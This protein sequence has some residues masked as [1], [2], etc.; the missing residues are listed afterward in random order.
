MSFEIIQ[1]NLKLLDAEK[2]LFSHKTS[3]DISV[4][5]VYPNNY[6]AGMSNLGF[7]KVY[8]IINEIPEFFCDRAFLPDSKIMK[9]YGKSRRKLLSMAA[10]KPLQEFHILAFSISYEPDFL[11]IPKILDLSGIPIL[12]KDRKKSYPLLIAG[13]AAV[14][15][16]PEIVSSIFDLI[17]PGEAEEIL[18]KVLELYGRGGFNDKQAYIQE[19]AHISGVYAPSLFHISYDINGCISHVDNPHNLEFPVKMNRTRLLRSPA[20]SSIITNETEFSG[21]FLVEIS[22][23]CPFNCSFCHIGSSGAY[24]KVPMNEVIQAIDMGMKHTCK[25]GLLGAAVGSHPQLMDI[26]NYI[27]GKKGQVSFSSLRADVL[28]PK[29][30]QIFK[31]LGQNTITLAPESGSENLRKIL[32]KKMTNRQIMDVT[33]RAL[34]AGF[35]E[36]RLYFMTG[37]PGETLE[38]IEQTIDLIAKIDYAAKQK[39]AKILVSLNQFVP[40]PGTQLELFPLEKEETVYDK[41]ALIKQPFLKSSAVEFKVESL[42]EI[43]LQGF[44]ARANRS[45][46]DFLLN[47]YSKA[48][49][50]FAAKIKKA[51]LKKPEFESLLYQNI[52]LQQT[53]PW[54]VLQP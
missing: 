45:M 15:I 39:G 50:A 2:H 53:P 11:N 41:I 24:R 9:I 47:N 31:K 12:A 8:S 16:N 35:K 36:I 43:L 18:Q 1:H 32:N 5:L 19:A 54:R 21:I 7:L 44:L 17:I 25:I 28:E 46:A 38:D 22:R 3:G 52:S 27:D 51:A 20:F 33:Q 4:C 10:E 23:G 48:P 14:S 13:G 49:S 40:K 37:I 34:E 26:L 42:K 6:Y 30:I 29:L